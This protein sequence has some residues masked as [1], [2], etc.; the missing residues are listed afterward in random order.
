MRKVRIVGHAR[1][2]IE[3]RQVNYLSPGMLLIL[4]R[5][6]HFGAF[7]GRRFERRSDAAPKR[8]GFGSL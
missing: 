2:L 6:D 5:L 4:S 1:N 8:A 3:N 7:G